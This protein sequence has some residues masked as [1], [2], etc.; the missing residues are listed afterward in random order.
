MEDRDYITSYG[1]KYGNG[2]IWFSLYHYYDETDDTMFYI[3]FYELF[4]DAESTNAKSKRYSNK[5]MVLDAKLDNS[6]LVNFYS[7]PVRNN[8]LTKVIT[9]SAGLSASNFNYSYSVSEEVSKVIYDYTNSPSKGKLN[10]YLK[11]DDYYDNSN[12][13]YPYVGLYTERGNIL[14]QVEKFTTK[15]KDN[16]ELNL[17]YKGRILKDGKWENYTF[18]ETFSYTATFNKN[19]N[20]FSLNE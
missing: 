1:N 9:N 16:D 11:F 5:S 17:T 19:K 12:N 13:S 3:L 7:G 10:M 2:G 15:M 18:L 14:F 6:Q 8:S 20:R 4:I